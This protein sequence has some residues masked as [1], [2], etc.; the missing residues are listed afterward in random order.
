MAFEDTLVEENPRLGNPFSALRQG[1][2]NLGTTLKAGAFLVVCAGCAI[3]YQ[4]YMAATAPKP[5]EITSHAVMEKLL[6]VQDLATM[7]TTYQGVTSVTNPSNLNDVYYYISYEGEITGG[8]DFNAIDMDL[9]HDN[10]TLTISLPPSKITGTNVDISSLDY[11]FL[12]E[13]YNNETVAATALQ[14]CV[15]DLTVEAMSLRALLEMSSENAENTVLAL[16]M[17]FMESLG[18]DY[19]LV[20]Q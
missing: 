11:L 20:L 18:D 3:T 15:D 1:L 4:R 19:S 12:N 10:K 5:V 16:T 14:T 2:K 13:K 17:P 7:K 8:V 6:D 9:N